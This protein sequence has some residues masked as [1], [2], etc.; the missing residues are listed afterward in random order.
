MKKPIVDALV[1]PLLS[2]WT[3][4]YT[5]VISP[6]VAVTA[7]ATSNAR[8]ACSSLDS[9]IRRSESTNVA[10]PTGTLT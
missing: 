10:M 4:A 2:A 7:P 8:A 3:I 5:S 9:G 6:P 1:Q